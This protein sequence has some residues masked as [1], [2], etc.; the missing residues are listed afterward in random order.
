[1]AVEMTTNK[2]VVEDESS[3]E[4]IWKNDTEK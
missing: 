1:M 2:Y 3:K 4:E